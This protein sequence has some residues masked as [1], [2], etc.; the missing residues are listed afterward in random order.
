MCLPGVT[1]SF[2]PSQFFL[3][4]KNG[5]ARSFPG[6]KTDQSVFPP[7]KDLT[8]QFFPHPVSFFPHV[9]FLKRLENI[10]V[11]VDLNQINSCIITLPPPT[12]HKSAE[13]KEGF[14]YKWLA[15]SK[16]KI[17]MF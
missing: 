10:C 4:G 6:E 2:L 17:S 9:T 7:R 15:Y 1:V 12:Q 8:S 11:I 3:R 5:L 14:D 13:G 16:N